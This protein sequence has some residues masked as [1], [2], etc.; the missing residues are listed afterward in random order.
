MEKKRG[1]R[2]LKLKFRCCYIIIRNCYNIVILLLDIV[3]IRK[4]QN[5]QYY[6]DV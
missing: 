4:V 2:L 3:K 5:I 1:K 6:V